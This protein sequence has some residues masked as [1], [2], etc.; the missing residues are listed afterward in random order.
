M[1][2]ARQSVLT[3]REQLFLR[4]SKSTNNFEPLPGDPISDDR[5][6]DHALR[7]DI[8]VSIYTI[9]MTFYIYERLK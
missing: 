4:D 5:A 8:S 2:S 3:C 9:R 1:R 7:L 6:A